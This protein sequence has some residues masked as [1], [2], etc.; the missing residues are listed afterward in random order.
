MGPCKVRNEIETKLNET[1]QIETKRNKF[2]LSDVHILVNIC[3]DVF[4]FALQS[5]R[6]TVFLVCLTVLC[7]LK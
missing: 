7:L 2:C 5:D 4:E 1:L 6:S 3:V